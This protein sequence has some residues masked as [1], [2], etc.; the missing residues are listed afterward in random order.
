MPPRVFGGAIVTKTARNCLPC[1]RSV[2]QLPEADAYSPGVTVGVCPISVIRSRSPL[3]FSRRTQNPVS[4][5][6]N[7]TLSTSPE[8]WSIA[9]TG[10]LAFMGPKSAS[11]AGLAALPSMSG[12]EFTLL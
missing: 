11:V 10:T 12:A 8:S 7:V 4:V 6:W 9:G 5:L 1:S 2:T 3:T